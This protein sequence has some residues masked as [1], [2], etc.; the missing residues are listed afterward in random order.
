MRTKCTSQIG[1]F[2]QFA[3]HDIGRE[4]AAM[5]ASLDAHVTVLKWAA[6]DLKT[7]AAKATGRLGM[8]VESVLRRALL[9]QHW[10]LSYEELA[11]HLLDSASFHSFA[12]LPVKFMPKKL[13]LQS[14][15]SP[16]F[17]Q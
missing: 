4:Q 10:Q 5:S 17:C 6:K 13:I 12:W 3:P 7:A 2:S 9:M 14:F 1:K 15:M 11:F 16:L 8:G